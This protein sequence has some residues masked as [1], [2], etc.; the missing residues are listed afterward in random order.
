MSTFSFFFK[1]ALYLSSEIKPNLYIDCSDVEASHSA[2]IDKFTFDE[3]FY[4]QSRGISYDEALK[5]LIKGFLLSD[6][7]D[8]NLIKYI[9][10]IF[11][12]I[13]R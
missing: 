1:K 8:S 5:L 4:L 12:S 7:S 2:L 9:N 6:I 11:N 10:K 3:I 13:W